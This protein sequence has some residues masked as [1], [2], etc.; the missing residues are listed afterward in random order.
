VEFEG[1]FA[2]TQQFLTILERLQPLLV[3]RNLTTELN[4]KNPVLEG[5]YQNG[6]F[7]PATEQPQRRLTTAFDLHALLPL[8][9]EQVEAAAAEAEKAAEEAE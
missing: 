5:E 2:Q 3:V 6:K 9:Q 4:E 7:V 8:S 1:S